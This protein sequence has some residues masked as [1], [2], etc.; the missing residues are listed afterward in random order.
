MESWQEVAV[1]LI[2]PWKIHDQEGTE[3]IFQAL[4]AID[5]S[6]NLLEIARIDRK[7]AEYI[8]HRFQTTWIS[9]YPLP[10]CCVHDNGGEFTGHHF[11]QLL[12]RYNITDVPT[13]V[14]NPQANAVCE[15]VHQAVASMI[16]TH[17]HTNPPASQD[18]ARNLIDHCLAMEMLATQSTH[19][20]TLHA[21][22][23]FIAFHRDM[24]LNIPMIA[25]ILDIQQRQQ[26]KVDLALQQHNAS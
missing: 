11:Q 18:D 13:T 26:H 4:T 16:R 7:S 9:R 3:Y 15:Q 14:K 24:Q 2:G 6:T 25:N 1:D 19:N 22:P 5:T 8:A 20:R 21:S 17:V 10:S 23:G 12:R